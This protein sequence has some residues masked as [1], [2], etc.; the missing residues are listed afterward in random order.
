MKGRKKALCAH[1][2]ELCLVFTIPRHI[3]IHFFLFF[4]LFCPHFQNYMADEHVNANEQR[5]ALY[6]F[7]RNIL[8]LIILAFRI[9]CMW[10]VWTVIL[11][12]VREKSLMRFFSLSLSLSR[13]C[14]SIWFAVFYESCNTT[15]NL[16]ENKQK[17][18]WVTSCS[19]CFEWER[20]R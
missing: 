19:V 5:N 7:A 13:L 14:V 11:L 18:S 17:S 3:Y 9:C 2:S 8:C 12:M 1:T 6:C 20:E 10:M 4:Y 15:D 16:G